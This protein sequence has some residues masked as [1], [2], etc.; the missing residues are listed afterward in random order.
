M[1]R[2]IVISRKW[3]NAKI[4]IGVNVHGQGIVMSLEDFETALS[5]ELGLDIKKLREASAK[6]TLEM[7][8]ATARVGIKK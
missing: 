7:K 4:E 8:S 5:L 6:I 1:R 2:D 3:N